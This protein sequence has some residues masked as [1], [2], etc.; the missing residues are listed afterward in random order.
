MVKGINKL[1]LVMGPQLSHDENFKF[2]EPP[3]VFLE[4]LKSFPLISTMRSVKLRLVARR[5]L[6]RDPESCAFLEPTIFSFSLW[7]TRARKFRN[8]FPLTSMARGILELQTRATIRNNRT[9]YTY[10]FCTVAIGSSFSCFRKI[11]RDCKKFT[12]LHLSHDYFSI[13]LIAIKTN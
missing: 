8:Q 9:I 4:I 6:S 1:W 12:I 2:L 7:V 11:W 3:P 10:N 13:A 5:R